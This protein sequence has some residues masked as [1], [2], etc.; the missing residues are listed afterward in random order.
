MTY[1]E[2]LDYLFQQLPMYQ[3]E[4]KS[5]FKKDLKNIL[6]ICS[7][8]EEPHTQFPSVHIAGT[9]GKGSTAHLLCSVLQESGY[10]VGLY[11]SPHLKDFRERI[12][13][14]G[15]MISE[16]EVIQFV[17]N[18]FESFSEIKPSF[19]EWTVALAFHHFKIQ[20]VDIA[21]IET[22]LGG[23][24]DSTNIIKPEL[25]IITNIGFD[26][27]EMLGDTLDKIAFEKA[28]IIKPNTP[29]VIGNHSGQKDVFQEKANSCDS[30]IVFANEAKAQS[31]SSDL[32]G[33]YQK[34]NIQTVISSIEELRKQGWK[35]SEQSLKNGLLNTVKNTGLKGRWQIAQT[36][37]KIILETAHNEEGLKMAMN[38]LNQENFRH[39]HLVLGFVKDKSIDKLL[40]LLPK[41]ASYYFCQAQIPRSLD[42]NTL[43]TQAKDY[44]LIGDTFSSVKNALDAAKSNAHKEDLIYVGGSNFI[45]AEVL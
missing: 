37:P 39:R 13:I 20:K 18:H 41:D 38:Q 42:V 6:K 24:L 29:V 11:T 15:E 33:N 21:I 23:R 26:H 1:Q 32:K 3:R 35:I 25:S 44:Q 9:N 2:T 4:G 16:T 31:Y 14:N 45:V 7:L 5:A 28:G 22:G 30:K 27:V 10:R 12:R 17:E 34:E 43:K 40:N 36:S 8:L 19:F